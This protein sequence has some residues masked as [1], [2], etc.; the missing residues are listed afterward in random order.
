MTLNMGRYDRAIRLATAVLLFLI[1]FF[2]LGGSGQWIAA[3]VGVVLAAT[4]SVGTCPLYLPF[5]LSTRQRTNEG[6]A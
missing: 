3:G 1:A 2:L 5:G 6:D 4:A